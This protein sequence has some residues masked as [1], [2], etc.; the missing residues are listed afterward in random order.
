MWVWLWVAVAWAA[1]MAVL[2]WTPFLSLW[3]LTSL[4]ASGRVGAP[5]LDPRPSSS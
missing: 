2:L 5:G 3:P 4:K 1:P